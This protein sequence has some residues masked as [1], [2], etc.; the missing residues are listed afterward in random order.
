[1]KFGIFLSLSDSSYHGSYYP[2]LV[3]SGCE[4]KVLN[5]LNEGYHGNKFSDVIDYHPIF[6]E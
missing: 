3:I 4:G 1:M 5:P 6:D 2:M